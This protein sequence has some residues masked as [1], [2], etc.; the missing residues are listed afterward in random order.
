[1]AVWKLKSC[2][3]CSGDLYIQRETDGW[4]EECL[5]CGYQRDVSKLVAMNI[6]GQIKVKNPT[7]ARETLSS[8]VRISSAN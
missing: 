8:D 3:R 5:L 7:E 1:M 6:V 4:Y 2:P